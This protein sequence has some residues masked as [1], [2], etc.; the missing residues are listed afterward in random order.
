MAGGRATSPV[1]TMI[2]QPVE[3]TKIHYYDARKEIATVSREVFD[4]H[5]NANVV[6]EKNLFRHRWVLKINEIG[7][8][9]D[10]VRWRLVVCILVLSCLV[11]AVVFGVYFGLFGSKRVQVVY[12][13]GSNRS[14]AT[15]L[16]TSQLTHEKVRFL[17]VCDAY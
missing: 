5:L 14:S 4:N 10:R 11:V 3:L 1:A 12:T 2:L 9:R 8:G 6:V 7:G 17:R 16:P 13:F 15:V